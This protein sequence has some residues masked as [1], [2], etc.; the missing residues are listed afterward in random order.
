MKTG[1]HR[2]ALEIES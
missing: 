2:G 1:R